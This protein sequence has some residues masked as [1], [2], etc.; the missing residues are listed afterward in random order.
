VTGLVVAIVLLAQTPPGQGPVRVVPG[1]EPETRMLYRALKAGEQR[2]EGLLR[3]IECPPGRPVAFVLQLPDKTPAKYAAPTL[4]SVEFIAHTPSFRGPVS[5][6]PDAA[7]SR[8]PDVD[9][10]GASCGGAG[11]PS[12]EIVPT[13][14]CQGLTAAPRH[15]GDTK[16]TKTTKTL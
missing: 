3:R 6:R 16:T 8:L 9:L 13:R 11:I 15:G 14:R 1:A 12:S 5:W 10:R 2:V 7:G 4:G